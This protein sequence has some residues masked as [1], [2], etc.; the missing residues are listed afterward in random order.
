MGLNKRLKQAKRELRNEL[1]S[2]LLNNNITPENTNKF[3][4][5]AI[6]KAT[7]KKACKQLKK[8]L[9]SQ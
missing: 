9:K 3:E 6:Y 7:Y 4:Y 8:Q 1:H 5:D 2:A